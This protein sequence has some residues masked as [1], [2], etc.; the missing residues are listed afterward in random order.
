MLVVCR[1]SF[2]GCCEVCIGG[3]LEPTWNNCVGAPASHRSNC[4]AFPPLFS[5]RALGVHHPSPQPPVQDD[6]KQ[7]Q[8]LPAITATLSPQF[9]SL[10]STLEQQQ[11]ALATTTWNLYAP[12]I[13]F[14]ASFLSYHLFFLQC[15]LIIFN[16]VLFSFHLS[17]IFYLTFHPLFPYLFTV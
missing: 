1:C 17:S 11:S 10:F 13:Q 16:R 12:H 14:L 8:S 5:S 3:T 15:L 7:I 9:H 4:I 2:S 6:C